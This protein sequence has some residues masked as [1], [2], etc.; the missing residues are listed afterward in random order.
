L[1]KIGLFKKIKISKIKKIF[2]IVSNWLG[3]KT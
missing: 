3:N 1:L 2:K